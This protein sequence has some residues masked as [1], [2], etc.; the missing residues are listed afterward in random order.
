MGLPVMVPPLRARADV[1]QLIAH[2]LMSQG[3]GE[4]IYTVSEEAKNLLLSYSWLGNVREL[5][6]ARCSLRAR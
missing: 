3:R 1:K 5:Q 4:K 6:Q 2:F